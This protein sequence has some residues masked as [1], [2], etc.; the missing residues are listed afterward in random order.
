[1]NAAKRA[2]AEADHRRRLDRIRPQSRCSERAPWADLFPNGCRVRIPESY[3]VFK[4]RIGT[5]TRNSRYGVYVLLDMLEREYS[6]KEELIPEAYQPGKPGGP[7]PLQR[8]P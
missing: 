6:V 4:G 7:P 8:L 3:P 1:M 5:V 2:H